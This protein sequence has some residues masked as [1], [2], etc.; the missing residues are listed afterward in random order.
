M[1]NTDRQ[2]TTNIEVRWLMRTENNNGKMEA[3]RIANYEENRIMK[4]TYKD[5]GYESL[6]P[7]GEP[8]QDINRKREIK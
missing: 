1:R 8:A 5:H 7:S 4:K 3:W 2:R 6:L